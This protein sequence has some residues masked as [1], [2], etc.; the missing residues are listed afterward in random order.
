MTFAD[1]IRSRKPVRRPHWRDD[2]WIELCQNGL[3]HDSLWFDNKGAQLPVGETGCTR[4]EWRFNVLDFEATD[5][6]FFVK[7]EPTYNYY[8]SSISFNGEVLYRRVGKK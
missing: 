1:A 4:G 5:W 7:E 3:L 8:E 2:Y 6:E